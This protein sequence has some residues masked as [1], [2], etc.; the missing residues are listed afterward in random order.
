MKTLLIL[1]V[2]LLISMS[3]FTQP[4]S[5]NYKAVVKD[6]SG[7]LVVSQT[8]DVTFTILKNSDNSVIYEET[9]TNETTDANGLMILN[10]GGGSSTGSIVNVNWGSDI[11]LLK[12]EIDLEQDGSFIN[13]GTTSFK[14]VPYAL[15]APDR[16]TGL[17]LITENANTGWRLIGSDPNNFGS[18]GLFA[19]DLSIA[20]TDAND[21]G[22]TNFYSVAIGNK[23]RASGE[24]SI[25]IGSGTTA[26]AYRSTAM[27][28]NNV[29]GGSIDSWVPED[30]LF[31]IGNGID[32]NNKSNALTV[33]KNGTITAPSFDLAEITDNKALITKEFADANYNTVPF[34]GDYND[35]SNQPTIILP[36]GLEKVTDVNSGWRLKGTSSTDF[37]HA[38]I[39]INAVDLAITNGTI[40]GIGA[41]GPESFAS[42]LNTKA[43]ASY[44]TAM[45]NNTSAIGENSTAMGQHTITTANSA[46]AIGKFNVSE[47]DGLFMIGNGT[48]SGN[49]NNALIVRNN[50]DAQFDGEIQHTS[51]GAANMIPIAYGT[52]ESNGNVFSGTGNFTADEDAGIITIN[53]AGETLSAS[54]SSCSITPYS[55]TFRSSSVLHSGG[56]LDVYIYD[57]SG[58]KNATTFQFVIYKL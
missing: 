9:H 14:A 40:T 11:H 58:N 24:E 46:T 53:V 10:I 7:N 50:G 52:V 31:E 6:G 33:L 26:E 1:F 17:E 57:I 19:L 43:I 5:I 51:T 13:L 54:N 55:S 20:A 30:P 3:G 21:Y 41:G 16:S 8:F 18:I 28:S 49:R 32:S 36:T 37:F 35:L 22:A 48:S 4:E 29:G 15:F 42:G 12:T 44:A 2:T 25:S 56:N 23:V 45:G 27:G 39:G 38:N 47:T 34:S